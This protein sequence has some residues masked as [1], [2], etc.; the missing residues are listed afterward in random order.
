MSYL[1]MIMLPND[2]LTT[3]NLWSVYRFSLSLS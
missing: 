3:A 1:F 2:Y